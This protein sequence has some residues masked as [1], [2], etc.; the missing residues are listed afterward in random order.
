M[1]SED[2]KHPNVEC[3]NDDIGNKNVKCNLLI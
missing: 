3:W 1:L 2:A